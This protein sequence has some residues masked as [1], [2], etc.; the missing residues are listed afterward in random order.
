M[1]EQQHA[2]VR[3]PIKE[4]EITN[5]GASYTSTPTVTLSSGSGAV[6]QPIVNDGKI[7]SIAII[8]AGSGYTTAPEVQIQ[9]DGFGAV[10]RATIDTD[11]EN[12]GK[13]TG[14]TI[15][16]RGVGYTQGQTL[17]NLTSVGQDA[18][19]SAEVFKWTY[20]LQETND[21]DS[22]KGFVSEGYNTQ[23]GGEYAHLSNPQRLRYILGDNLFEN[24]AGTIL[25]RDE[26][27]THSPIIG[28][29]FDG[30]PIYGPYGYTDPTDQGSEI[31]RMRS[32]YALKTELVQD[33]QTNPYPVRTAGPLLTEEPAG[34][35]VED[36]KYSFNSGD[37]DQYNGRFCKTPDYP[38]GRYCYFVTID[39]T[40]AGN[41]VFPYVLGPSFN[42]VVDKWNLSATAVQQN[43]PTGVVRYRDPYENVDIDVERAPN[44]STNALTLENGDILLFE[45]EDEDRSGVIDQ[46]ELD[47]PDQVFEESPLQLYDYFP[48]V[49]F[50]SK[51][52]IEVE[53]TTKFE[54]AS[55]TGFTIENAGKSYQ[56]DDRLV[57]DNTDTDGTGVSAR[58][59]RIKGEDIESY[60]FESISGQ[61]YGVLTTEEPHNL[62]V[63]DT[64]FVDYTPVMD[65]TNKQYTVRQYKGIE[66]IVINQTGSGYNEDIP[67]VI[68]IDSASGE[69]G[70][71][72]AVVDAVGAI[73]K[74]NILNSGS[75]YTSNPRVI[76]SHPQIFKK[77]DYYVSLINNNDYV[78]IN[79]VFVNDSK[80]VFVCGKTKDSSDNVVA[81]VAKLSATGVKEWEKTLELGTGQQY[82]EFQKV[83]VDGND[84]WVVGN[85]QPNTSVLDAYNPDIILAKY[86]QADNGLSATLSFQKGY[87]GISGSSRS[88][89]VTSLVQ[90][91]STR[92][93]I[94]GYTDTN[95]ANPYDAFLASIDTSGNFS[96]K[97]K[98][99]SAGKSEKITD[100]IVNGTDVYFIMEVATSQNE[101]DI[102]IAVGKASIGTSAI[103][104]SWIKTYPNTLYSM[105]NASLCID[106]FNEIYMVANCRLKSDD[107][108][109]DSVW[110]GKI[111][112]D[113]DL[114]WNY[115]Y[116]APGREVTMIGNSEID[117]FGDLN[118]GFTRDEQ[119]TGKKTVD[120]LK[121]GYDGKIKNHTTTDFD[122]ANIEGLTAHSLDVDQSGDIHVFGQIA[123]NR[124][125]FIFPFT[126]GSTTTDTTT[127]Y[128][129]TTT[130]TGSSLD[131]D[132]GFAKIYGYQDG[133]STWTQGNLKVTGTQLSDKLDSNFLIEMQIFKDTS[134]TSL[135]GITEN[136]LLSIGDAADGTGG[137]WL[138]YDLADGKLA[139]VVTNNSTSINS[140]TAVKS[141]QTTM[142]ADDTW[143]FIALRK[144]GTTFN[145]YVNGI[146]VITATLSDTDFEDKD[147]L[148]GQVSGRD[149]STGSFRVDE[150]GQYILDSLRL[151]NRAVT[152]TVPSDVTMLSF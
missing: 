59:S 12:A 120:T 107:T 46:A 125:E 64:V 32:S 79:D 105:L 69:D 63:G 150:Q 110:V 84:I 127:H 50:D 103:T 7:I 102:D 83:F 61:N 26:Q 10:A 20:N 78:K 134:F 66:E 27:L 122:E 140:G 34:K 43:I 29:A 139:L 123:W 93:L 58:I 131:Y 23:Y 30:N 94:G 42:S 145:V 146:S 40:E 128:T 47:D 16:N 45:V 133:E 112:T 76:L 98:F 135:S 86:V 41:P 18:T 141:T 70:S 129:L 115:R 17:I 54:N 117:I 44:A 106:E 92:F 143:Q 11:G 3:G 24:N 56:V 65:N 73:K 36:Y 126:T 31:I 132:G 138:Y 130:S 111:D 75:G 95:S 9:G 57:F 25:E 14:I 147:L 60:T 104:T 53:T 72:Q 37:L 6:A 99:A 142:F 38:N 116:V 28:W 81:F 119:T 8:S 88:D 15:V 82:A 68:T 97:R 151:R 109:R 22:A 144:S 67:P 33:D 77:A 4:V 62:S 149:G 52:D 5:G 71:L 100:V 48:K 152:P 51:V 90:Y 80:E 13:V 113:G 121:I 137:L 96:V 35:F 108:T 19:F 2:S 148:I 39:A 55:V 124:N 101:N 74:V 21:L 87:A 1:L 49:K 85:N 91:S 118:I 114:I 136:T 89:N